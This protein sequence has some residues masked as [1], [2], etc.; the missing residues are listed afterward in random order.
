MSVFFR[1]FTKDYRAERDPPPI[2]QLFDF[3]DLETFSLR[4]EPAFYSNGYFNLDPG[5][6]SSLNFNSYPFSLEYWITEIEPIFKRLWD[7]LIRQC[8]DLRGFSILTRGLDPVNSIDARTLFSGDHWPRLSSLELGNVTVGPPV[9]ED[10]D[11]H[12]F[13]TFLSQ[14]N[15]L[16][17]L[18]FSGDFTL[19]STHLVRLPRDSLGDLTCFSGSIDYLSSLPSAK[20]LLSMEISNP[21]ILREV[22]PLTISQALQAAPAVRSLKVSFVL[23]SGYD[24]IGILRSIATAGAHVKHLDLTFSHKPSFYLVCPLDYRTGAHFADEFLCRKCFRGR[25]DPSQNFGL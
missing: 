12:P 11:T 2:L 1:L 20:S 24:G 25:S 22:T 23:Q 16:Q 13:I 6:D 19:S 3:K 10:G 5:G 18:R 4:F 15:H 21:L 14:R 9:L 17:T 8:P 7:M